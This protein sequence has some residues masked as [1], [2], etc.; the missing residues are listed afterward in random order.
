MKNKCNSVLDKLKNKSKIT[1]VGFQQLLQLLC[2]EEFLRRLSRTQYMDKYI[3]K[4][5]L[6]IYILSDF[7]SRATIDMDFMLKNQSNNIDNLILS[8]K[9][10]INVKTEN[11]FIIFE[12]I[13]TKQITLE[14]KYPGVSVQMIGKVGNTRTPVNIDFGIGDVITPSPEIR[15][16]KAQLNEFNDVCVNTYSLE[17]TVAEKFDAILQ[18]FELT[19]RMKDFYD[20][21][22]IATT[23]DFDGELLS[24]A[25]KSTL[26]NRGT[27]IEKESIER[28][29]RLSE[30]PVI[31]TRWNTFC[32]KMKI[33]LEIRECIEMIGRL[34]NPV[35]ENIIKNQIHYDVWKSSEKSWRK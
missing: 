9:E 5:G 34:L 6:F 1:G 25:V 23:F 7:Q 31:L 18:R 2:Q 3:L 12:I 32:K 17:S 24:R 16:M 35:T 30:N 19:S 33:N 11:D 28:I 4:G 13:D 8:I 14:K 20:I 10:I 22:Y 27:V 15:V 26:L 21:W 29:I